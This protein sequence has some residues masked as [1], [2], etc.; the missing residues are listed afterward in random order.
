MQ[1]ED[2]LDQFIL[3]QVADQLGADES[4]KLCAYLV[5]EGASGL[6][7]N[8]KVWFLVLTDKNLFRIQTRVGAFKPIR[9][10]KGI[11]VDP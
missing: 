2:D 9:E 11:Q 10:N 7:V 1:A 8:P 5:E 6:A 3:D 4:V